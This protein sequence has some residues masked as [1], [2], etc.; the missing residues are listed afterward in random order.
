[1]KDDWKTTLFGFLAAIGVAIQPIII[2]GKINY[3]AIVIAA[4][5]AIFAYYSKDK[6]KV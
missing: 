6:K 4:L 5:L 2:S 3:P 1:M